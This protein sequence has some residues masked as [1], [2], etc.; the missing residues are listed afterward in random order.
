MYFEGSFQTR[1]I[2][3][4]VTHVVLKGSKKTATEL[5]DKLITSKVLVSLAEWKDEEEEWEGRGGEG[6]KGREEVKK[7]MRHKRLRST[8]AK[9]EL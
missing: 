2:T 5:P 8:K 1:A 7:K 6:G 9:I 3:S 4:F